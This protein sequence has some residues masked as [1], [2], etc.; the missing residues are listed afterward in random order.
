[1]VSRL[2]AL[3]TA[4]AV[5]QAPVPV[6]AVRNLFEQLHRPLRVL[7][8]CGDARSRVLAR[9][10]RVLRYK[11]SEQFLADN[12]EAVTAAAERGAALYFERCVQEGLAATE[13]YDRLVEYQSDEPSTKAELSIALHEMGLTGGDND[14]LAIELKKK[15]G[16]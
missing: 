2:A 10:W 8:D 7:S 4:V 6:E 16:G 15:E 1:M 9:N 3:M 11:F 14:G 12:A 5:L 13:A